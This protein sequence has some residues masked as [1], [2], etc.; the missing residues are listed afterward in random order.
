MRDSVPDRAR[1]L[2]AV[3]EAYAMADHRQRAAPIAPVPESGPAPVT[4]REPPL[5]Q[6][7]GKKLRQLLQELIAEAAAAGQLRDDIAPD[8][9]AEYCIHSLAVAGRLPHPAGV[10]RLVDITIAGLRPGVASPG[11]VEPG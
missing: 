5:E 10:R 3:L 1:C 8:E 2:P 11:A 7:A 4:H 9:L 6:A